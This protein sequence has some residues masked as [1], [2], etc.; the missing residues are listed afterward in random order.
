MYIMPDGSVTDKTPRITIDRENGLGW[1]E[2][3][4]K[5]TMSE[6]MA[7]K[8]FKQELEMIEKAK[9]N[10]LNPAKRHWVETGCDDRL[11]GTYSFD[12]FAHEAITILQVGNVYRNGTFDYDGYNKA[13][14][15][16]IEWMIASIEIVYPKVEKEAK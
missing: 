6:Y 9:K 14:I 15:D 5:N 2:I 11:P 10:K 8:I 4:D 3:A 16:L 1:K 13:I 7:H 12:W